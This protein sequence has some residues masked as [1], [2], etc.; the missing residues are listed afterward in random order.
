[1]VWSNQTSEERR[2]RLCHGFLAI[3]SISSGQGVKILTA[4]YWYE[5]GQV[6]AT[7]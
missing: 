2:L 4:T 7:F 1:M 6:A 5:M 3:E